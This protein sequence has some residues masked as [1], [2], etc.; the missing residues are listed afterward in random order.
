[1]KKSLLSF[2]FLCFFSFASKA[3][4]MVSK[5]IGK[6]VSEYGLGYG[7]FSY[8]DFPLA[9]ENQSVRIELVD[10]AFF[11]KKGELDE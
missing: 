10:F 2:G 6:D 1:M 9:N 4:F 5:M 8:L 3:Q 7:L 11:P